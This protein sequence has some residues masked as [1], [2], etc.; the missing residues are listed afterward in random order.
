MN[1]TYVLDSLPVLEDLPDMLVFEASVLSSR[2]DCCCNVDGLLNIKQCQV[3]YNGQ[4]K[5]L[6]TVI[7]NNGL[8]SRPNTRQTRVTSLG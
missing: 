5:K 4:F 2:S 8:H 7:T 3:I 6:Q 1:L